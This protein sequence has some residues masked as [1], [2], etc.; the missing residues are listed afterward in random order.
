MKKIFKAFATLVLFVAVFPLL[1][2]LAITALW[3]SIVVTTCGF[4]AITFW[5]GAGLF[6]L[7][8]IITGGFMIGLFLIGGCL[9]KIFHHEGDWHA[10]WHSMTAEERREFIER[11]RRE[12]FR[13]SNHKTSDAD[14]AE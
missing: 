12:L 6:L 2:A 3:N 14:A 5:Q 9:H 13:S 4:A 10:H 7:G 8:Q 11:R 1:A